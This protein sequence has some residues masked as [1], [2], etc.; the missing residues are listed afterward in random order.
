MSGIFLLRPL[1]LLALVPVVLAAAALRHRRLSGAWSAVVD[2]A[3]M[4]TL[5]RLG[6]LRDGGR[7]TLAVL[8]L[9]AAGVLALGLSGPAI[10]R[11]GAPAYRALDPLVLVLD[12]SPSIVADERALADL[13]TGAVG[14]LDAAGGRPVGMMVY[15]ADAYLASAPTTDVDSLRGLI[16]VLAHDTMPVA[17]SR[18]DIA[19]S[20]ARDLLTTGDEQGLGG[21]DLVLVTDGGGAGLR[22][23]EAAARLAHEGARIWALSV[24]AAAGAPPPDLEGLD[25]LTAAGGGG[26]LP[27]ADAATLWDRIA[28]AR[29]L[30]LA[31]EDTA[32]QGAYDLGPWALPMCL[33]I[34]LPLF[35]RQR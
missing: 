19:L 2:P 14:L 35:R 33:L 13:K 3:L 11:P 5:H 23:E 34:L 29:T 4:P 21:A 31:R 10:L 6:L 8:P 24:P 7:N 26:S 9:V 16:G 17:G 1:W 32:A 27:L 15:A 12:L 18:P 22:A 30:R 20:L 25:R 28:R